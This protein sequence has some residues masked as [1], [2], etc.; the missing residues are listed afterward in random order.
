MAGDDDVVNAVAGACVLAA[1]KK[2]S[3][4]IRLI[5]FGDEEQ[6]AGWKQFVT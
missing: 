3:K 2:D 4:F 6:A 5:D 1:Q